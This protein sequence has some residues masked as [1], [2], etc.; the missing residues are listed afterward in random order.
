MCVNLQSSLGVN[1]KASFNESGAKIS[2][3]EQPHQ[4]T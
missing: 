1:V 2:I 4:D 3:N